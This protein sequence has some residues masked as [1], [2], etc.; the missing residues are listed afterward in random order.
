MRSFA[1]LISYLLVRHPH[2][3]QKLRAEVTSAFTA[4]P[5]ID[6]RQLRSSR[7]LQNVLKESML[8]SRSCQLC[9]LTNILS[10][11]PVSAS[12]GKLPDSTKRHGAPSWRR[13][14]PQVSHLCAEWDD[15]SLLPVCFA[16]T[17][18][19][20]RHGRRGIS[21]GEMGRSCSPAPGPGR[22]K[23]GIYSLR[24]WPA[25]LSW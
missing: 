24:S 3:M 15:C 9:L 13:V 8:P 11:S 16:Q 6:R 2:V 17:A 12:A 21:A 1:Y 23:V 7:F 14:R 18:R 22:R 20:L 19:P 10:A 4:G 5:A 25:R